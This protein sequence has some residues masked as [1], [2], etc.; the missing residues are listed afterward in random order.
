M[1]ILVIYI[2]AGVFAKGDSVTLDNVPGF[3]SEAHCAA[4]GNALK[5][6]VKD[7]AKELRFVCLRNE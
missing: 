6:L 7:S 3:R 4:A 2:Y 5:P 1:W